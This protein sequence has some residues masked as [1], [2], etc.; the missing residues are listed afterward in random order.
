MRKLAKR[1]NMNERIDIVLRKFRSRMSAY[2][3]GMC[4]LALYRSLLQISMNQSCGKCVPCRD[5][6]VEVERMLT[7]ILN[8]CAASDSLKQLE[9]MCRMIA[10][11]ADCAVGVSAAH[12]ILDSLSEF[13]D[14]YESHLKHHSCTENV[15][16]TIPCVTLCPAHVDV[17]G[18]IALIKEE[19]YAGAIQVIRDRNPFPTACAMVCEH[20]CERKCRRAIID[21]PINI[22]GLKK[23]AVE[24]V[25][26]DTVPNPKRNVK[27]GKKVA[28]VGGGP[29]GLTAAYYLALMGHEVVIYEEHDKLGG[30]LRY[31]IPE[32]RLPKALLDVD[33]R[34]ILAVDGIEVKYHTRVGRDIS[35][36]QIRAQSDAVYL[37]LGAQIGNRLPVENADAVNVVPAA[38]FLQLVAGGMPPDLRDKKVA[39]IGGGNVAMDAARTA[40]RLKA[41]SVHVFTRKRDDYTALEEEMEGAMQEG[42]RFRTLL[43]FLHI[44][45]DKET[46]EVRAVW[47]QPQIVGELDKFGM[48][49]TEHS[50]NYPYR[51]QC[52]YLILGVG[53]RCDVEPFAAAG[54]P[55]DRGRILAGEDC[56][57]PDT[58]GVF[59]GG[60]CVTGPSTAINAI[61]AGQ[62]AAFN[63][64]EYLGYHHKLPC[65]AD[66]PAAMPNP[67]IP[68][69]RAEVETKDP[70]ERKENFEFVELPMTYEEAMRE[71][72]RCLRCDHYGCGAEEGGRGND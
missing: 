9:E 16:Q 24:S 25:A 32:Y 50:S 53:Q 34:A 26:A 68:T 67:C 2:P 66:V 56:I 21:D 33:L 17:P 12:L 38:D 40:I 7:D 61:A 54:I 48:M 43:S 28:V 42:V 8:G 55:V 70:F 19:D 64:D 29:S 62:V 58:E 14:E 11:C 6:L 18:Y 15:T 47:L 3:P 57:V 35:L 51:F 37:G 30:M 69:S 1:G 4:P 46:N 65:E 49:T 23:Y 45:T 20:P 36:D 39:L 72:G 5:G 59:S 71:S 52:D 27:T 31:G 44:E 10:D 63:I 13:A 41:K 60:D 22:R